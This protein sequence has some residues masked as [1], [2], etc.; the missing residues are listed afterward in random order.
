[1]T[2]DE[3]EIDDNMGSQSILINSKIYQR[4][5][6]VVCWPAYELELS[7]LPVAAGVSKYLF[8]SPVQ[9]GGGWWSM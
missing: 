9:A 8:T 3:L 7:F 6:Q 1:M 4:V 2:N 5:T